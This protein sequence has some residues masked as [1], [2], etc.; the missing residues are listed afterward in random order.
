MKKLAEVFKELSKK[1]P[2]FRKLYISTVSSEY[3][4]EVIGEPFKNHCDV[5]GFSKGNIYV[6]CESIYATELQFFKE[7]I[8]DRINEKLGE[9]MVKRVIIKGKRRHWNGL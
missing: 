3:F 8:R 6:E 7:K 9:D 1:N 2:L 4:K 5:V